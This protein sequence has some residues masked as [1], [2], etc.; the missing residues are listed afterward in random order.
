MP[1][2]HARFAPAAMLPV[3]RV[4]AAPRRLLVAASGGLDSTVLVHAAAA[5]RAALAPC[6]VRVVHV[7]HGLHPD[8][9]RW[10][11]HAVAQARALGLD[12]GVHR[13]DVATGGGASPEAAARDARYAALAAGMAPGEVLLTA[14]HADD[15]LETL[16][17]ALVRGAGVA[18]LAAMPVV[19]P[20]GPG[21]HVR[22]LLPFSRA[23]LAD[24]AR[25]EGLAWCDDPSNDDTRFARNY[26]R[27]EVVP[28][29]LRRWPAAAATGSRSAA[30]CAEAAQLANALAAIDLAACERDGQPVA[31]ALAN[32][33]PA[34]ARNALR[35]WLARAGIAPPPRHQLEHLLR[36]VVHGRRDGQP[37]VAWAGIEVRRHRDRL[38]ALAPPATPPRTPLALTP[39][40]PLDLG[41]LGVL[42]LV[43]CDGPGLSADALADAPL[44]VGFRRGGERLRPFGHGPRRALKKLLQEH[45]V[46][47]WMRAAL[48]LVYAGGRLVAVADLW[49]E[50][51]FAAPAGAPALRV[52]WE[53]HPPLR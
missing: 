41:P 43:R 15:Q 31:S 26:V 3:L 6:S 48:P 28:A 20:F 4:L 10:A 12:V 17:L 33:D 32:L 50:H 42:T 46:V 30:L 13:V 8:A 40:V 51:D 9:P 53:G 2:P 1:Q 18:G 49:L 14:H 34:R 35:A 45:G 16:L 36:E 11:E 5:L 39:D 19:A 37:R 38:Y 29:L 25:A 27:R 47:P 22:P 44:H 23:A 24:Y 21:A 7:N 52:R